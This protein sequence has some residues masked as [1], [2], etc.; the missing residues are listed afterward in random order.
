MAHIYCVMDFFDLF[1]PLSKWSNVQSTYV[2]GIHVGTNCVLVQPNI[3]IFSFVRLPSRQMEYFKF[4]F[5]NFR[6]P[7]VL[8]WFPILA[9]ARGAPP[10]D[11]SPGARGDGA[12]GHG[13]HVAGSLVGARRIA[14]HWPAR[15]ESDFRIA[16]KAHLTGDR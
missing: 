15:R 5:R 1:L 11:G 13:T 7:P 2:R 8:H 16:E 9:E 12:K 6:S 10:T 4:A 3:S 14:S